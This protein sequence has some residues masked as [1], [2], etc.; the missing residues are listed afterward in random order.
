M[1]IELFHG[2]KNITF[3]LFEVIE[4]KFWDFD[5]KKNCY[6]GM[7]NLYLKNEGY[8]LYNKRFLCYD[9]LNFDLFPLQPSSFWWFSK[10]LGGCD[11]R[12]CY[13]FWSVELETT[14]HSDL[15]DEKSFY[16]SPAIYGL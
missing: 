4:T 3:T 13:Q 6:S 11:T 5:L 1:V 12:E 2:I 7:I 9:V 14:H 16:Y 15:L 10:V 8:P